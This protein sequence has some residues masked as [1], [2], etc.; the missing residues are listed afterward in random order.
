M[1]IH[2]DASEQQMTFN[3]SSA[4]AA[5]DA[6]S[7]WLRNFSLHGPLDIRSIRVTE[8]GES[9]VATVVYSDASIDFT[10]RHF[11]E[12][13]PANPPMPLATPLDFVWP[14]KAA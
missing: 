6:A 11:P 9:F 1:T 10:P 5:R 12:P 7:A 8:D 4:C 2:S 3:G 13:K 14:G